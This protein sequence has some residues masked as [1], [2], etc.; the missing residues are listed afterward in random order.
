MFSLM[1]TLETV[2]EREQRA[3]QCEARDREGMLVAW[4]SELLYY[5]DAEELL[6]SR[7]TV[8]SLSSTRIEAVAF[9]EPIDRSRHDLHFG[10]KA[11]TR[12]MLRLAETAD[13]YEASILFDI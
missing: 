3:I 5:V 1:V 6:F 10:V 13:G 8:Q 9:G 4:L 7:F 12:H 11:V 2:V